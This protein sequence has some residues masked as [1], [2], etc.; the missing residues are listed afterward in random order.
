[1]DLNARFRLVS[2]RGSRDVPA[3]SFHQGA[4]ETGRAVDEILVGIIV[5]ATPGIR[6]AYLKLKHAASSWPIVT[7]FC[8]HVDGGPARI[9]LRLGGAAPVPLLM[10]WPSYASVDAEEVSAMDREAIDA[11]GTEWT[12]ELTSPGYRRSS[13]KRWPCVP[14]APRRDWPHKPPEMRLRCRINGQDFDRE[15]NQRL[16]LV[17]LVRYAAGLR[18]RGSAA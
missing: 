7:A 2:V 10:E 16:L 18:A 11:I 1:M 12:D 6:T 9:R 5:P 4:F 13:Q 3:A 17:K 14:S 15:V 8:L